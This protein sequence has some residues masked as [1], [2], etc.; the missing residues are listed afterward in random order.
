MQSN[1]ETWQYRDHVIASRLPELDGWLLC[2]DFDPI[3][4]E[5]EQQFIHYDELCCASSVEEAEVMSAVCFG[6]SLHEVS[7][8]YNAWRKCKLVF[9]DALSMLD[10]DMTHQ[11]ILEHDTYECLN[12]VLVHLKFTLP[13]FSVPHEMLHNL[14]SEDGISAY[15][16]IKT[17]RQICEVIF[18]STEVC[19]QVLYRIINIVN[20]VRT[21]NSYRAQGNTLWTR[22][23]LK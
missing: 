4:C 17:N 8:M 12:I 16:D 10:A 2:G 21:V 7:M 15:Y 11:Q 19:K 23:L 13:Y 3:D 1:L 5:Y 14:S 6:R 9:K 18:K 20:R 22:E